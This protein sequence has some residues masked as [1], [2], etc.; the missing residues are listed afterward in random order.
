MQSPVGARVLVINSSS[1]DGTVE[2]AAEM[3]AET[4]VVPRDEF[5]HG[6]S[7]EIARRHLGTDIVVM[8]S[9]DVYAESP[10]FL[11]HLIQP[12]ISG[13]AAMSYARQLPHEGASILERLP[14]WYSYPEASEIR[15]YD[16]VARIGPK[17]FF[18]SNAC[19]AY[20]NEALDRVGGFPPV[21]ALEDALVAARLLRKGER[22]AYVAE[23]R[24]HHSHNYSA[25]LE[26][27]RYFD[28]GFVRGLYREELLPTIGDEDDGW[29]LVRYMASH[30]SRTRKRLLPL[31]LFRLAGRYVG[32]RAGFASGRH[33]SRAV[34][35]LSSQDY[36][37]SPSYAWREEILRVSPIADS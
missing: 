13:Q 26:G 34:R 2:L 5:N 30:L 35:L 1:N 37:H 32:Y 14:R 9:P 15:T 11:A 33:P 29:G 27:R 4:L 10:A 36:I 6:V 23:A 12:L 19:A 21:L 24:V 28:I 22:I 17:A 20:L 25:W 16:D 3:G 18:C 31:L 7:R 8:M